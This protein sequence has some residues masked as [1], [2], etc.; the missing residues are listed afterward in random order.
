M[1]STLYGLLLFFYSTVLAFSQNGVP[2]A[3]ATPDVPLTAPA[4][5]PVTSERLAAECARLEA[6][7]A[8][9]DRERQRL[10]GRGTMPALAASLSFDERPL[11]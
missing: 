2:M 6:R 11:H 8:A 3:G 5:A 1:R 4:A 10:Q 9:L 7:S